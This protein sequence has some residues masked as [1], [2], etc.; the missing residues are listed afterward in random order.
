MGRLDD[1]VAVLLNA[2]PVN[3]EVLNGQA[4]PSTYLKAATDFLVLGNVNGVYKEWTKRLIDSISPL[5]SISTG[6]KTTTSLLTDV[7]VMADGSSRVAL[8]MKI[9]SDAIVLVEQALTARNNTRQASDATGAI[10]DSQ[11]SFRLLQLLKSDAAVLT[12]GVFQTA[13]RNKLAA[14]GLVLSDSGSASKVKTA[15]LSDGITASDVA[16]AYR[17][18]GRLGEDLLTV[19]SQQAYREFVKVLLDPVQLLDNY[20]KSQAVIQSKTATDALLV[21]DNLIKVAYRQKWL[22]DSVVLTDALTRISQLVKTAS[23][24]ITLIDSAATVKEKQRAMSDGLV[25]TDALLRTAIRGKTS[26]DAITFTDAIGTARR[27]MRLLSDSAKLVDEA[28][29]TRVVAGIVRFVTDTVTL[30]SQTV[31]KE[32]TL[33]MLDRALPS[34]QVQVPRRYLRTLFDALQLT[35]ESY[36]RFFRVRVLEDDML[37]VDTA[38]KAELGVKSRVLSDAMRLYD[39]NVFHGWA[40]TMSASLNL[41]DF[42]GVVAKPRVIVRSV[43]DSTLVVDYEKLTRQE[44]AMDVYTLEDHLYPIKYLEVIAEDT[45]PTSDSAAQALRRMRTLTS[46]AVMADALVA[47][48]GK[49]YVKVLGDYLYVSDQGQSYLIHRS[50]LTDNIPVTTDFAT[51]HTSR[52]I[53]VSDTLVL[54]DLSDMYRL[55]TREMIDAINA[56]RDERVSEKLFE[57]VDGLVL[58]DGVVTFR[59]YT[60]QLDSTLELADGFIANRVENNSVVVEDYVQLSDQAIITPRSFAVVSIRVHAGPDEFIEIGMDN[61]ITTANDDIVELGVA[62]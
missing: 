53:T 21:A 9:L 5:D 24:S 58:D 36:A 50:L 4:P 55:A 60:E 28:T 27:L 56:L 15:L 19:Y 3:S 39:A 52:R 33:R 51:A 8:R 47:S 62:A 18:L 13:L 6:A 26:Q 38:D 22:A 45:I 40:Y 31:Y 29:A 12:D 17:V 25:L 57:K 30:Y 48:F 10:A 7:L 59:Y 2:G 46:F 43:S 41:R 11:L 61:I 44:V 49:S 20:I 23:D 14:D 35:D 34:D 16:Q 32:M 37:L 1:G 54:R 42:L